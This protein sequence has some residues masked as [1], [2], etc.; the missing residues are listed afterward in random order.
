M[1]D[2]PYTTISVEEYTHMANVILFLREKVQK[3][4]EHLEKNEV[5]LA[6]ELL[7]QEKDG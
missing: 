3:A 7:R 2:G 6:L 5:D 1:N 4:R